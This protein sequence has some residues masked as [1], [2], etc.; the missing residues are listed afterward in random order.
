MPAVLC[1]RAHEIHL[2]IEGSTWPGRGANWELVGAVG[3][4][5]VLLGLVRPGI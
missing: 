1:D 4:A 3:S 5:F 2:R